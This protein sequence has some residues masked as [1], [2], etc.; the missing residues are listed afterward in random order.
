MYLNL[1]SDIVLIGQIWSKTMRDS[2]VPRFRYSWRMSDPVF[3]VQNE[4]LFNLYKNWASASVAANAS[5]SAD[6]A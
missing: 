2:Y 4:E 6:A 1:A 3:C 5:V